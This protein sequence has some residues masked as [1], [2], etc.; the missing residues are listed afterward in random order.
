M[1][2]VYR[3]DRAAVVFQQLEKGIDRFSTKISN[4]LTHALALEPPILRV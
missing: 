1:M 4:H 3:G 2:K